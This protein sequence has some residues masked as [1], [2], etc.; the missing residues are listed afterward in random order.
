MWEDHRAGGQGTWWEE[1]CLTLG[2]T[3]LGSTQPLLL[4]RFLFSS[5]PLPFP[6]LLLNSGRKKY[7]TIRLDL[8]M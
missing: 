7:L 4:S 6:F 3:Q 8:E 2:S 1:Q 5:H